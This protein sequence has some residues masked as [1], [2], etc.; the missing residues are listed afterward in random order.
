MGKREAVTQ[1]KNEKGKMENKRKRRKGRVE[2]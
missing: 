2:K 1:V